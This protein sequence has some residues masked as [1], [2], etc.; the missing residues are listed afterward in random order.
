MTFIPIENDPSRLD[1][2]ERLLTQ[3]RLDFFSQDEWDILAHLPISRHWMT[4]PEP[5][6]TET[7]F[8]EYKVAYL[9]D[10]LND[11]D[12]PPYITDPS[13]RLRLGLMRSDSH[14][15]CIPK[16][17][18]V[19]LGNLLHKLT[20]LNEDQERT[21]GLLLEDAHECHY[22]QSTGRADTARFFEVLKVLQATPLWAAYS[23]SYRKN[24]L[25]RLTRMSTARFLLSPSSKIAE[26]SSVEMTS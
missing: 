24:P 3:N 11:G 19:S 17:L 14:I 1:V 22:A 7:C 26:Q 5:K 9:E 20:L 2:L 10:I 6:T 13:E 23:R 21:L 4:S 18:R 16:A 12:E 8:L 25:A 15:L